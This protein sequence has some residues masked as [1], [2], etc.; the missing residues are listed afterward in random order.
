MKRVLC[1]MRHGLALEKNFDQTDFQRELDPSGIPKIIGHAHGL[2]S[3]LGAP[4]IIISSN[5]VRALETANYLAG[6]IKFPPEKIHANDNLY[7]APPRLLLQSVN[8]LKDEW[9]YVIIVGHNPSISYVAEYISDAEIG[10]MDPASI[11]IINFDVNSWSEI[12][13]GTG[14][15]NKYIL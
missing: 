3:E 8:H 10:S 11:V 4:Q 2:F 14:T 6:A 9:T 7:E 5:A 12:S 13:K 1:L 15:L